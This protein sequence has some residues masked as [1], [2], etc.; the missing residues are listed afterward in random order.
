MTWQTGQSGNPGGRKPGTGK[1]EK[2]RA[3]LARK[4]IV[5]RDADYVLVHV[6]FEKEPA[7]AAS[8][9]MAIRP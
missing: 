7:P 3:A 5:L 4:G 1:A 2:L 6:G 8:V 9:A